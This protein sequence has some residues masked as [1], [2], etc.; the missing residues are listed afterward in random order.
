ML[1]L[2]HCANYTREID[3][4]HDEYNTQIVFSVPYSHMMDN[5]VDNYT[6]F[7]IDMG[8]TFKDICVD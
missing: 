7:L 8:P 4:V 5:F 1:N 2:T 3:H 6:N